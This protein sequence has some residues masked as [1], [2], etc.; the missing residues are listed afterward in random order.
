MK[1][2]ITVLL[3][4]AF[5]MTGC[6][7]KEDPKT[8][9]VVQAI[10]SAEV[11]TTAVNEA[12]T[13]KQLKYV[14]QKGSEYIY[15]LTSIGSDV[16]SIKADTAMENAVQSKVTYKIGITPTEFDEDGT[17]TLNVAF[18]G[19]SLEAK[20]NKEKV[21]YQSGTKLDSTQ[22]AQ[23]FQYEALVNNSYGARLKNNGEILEIFKTDKIIQKIID[24]A[25]NMPKALTPEQK[26]QVKREVVESV[27]RPSLQQ[28]F[29]KLSDA[30][31]SANSN[32]SIDQVLPVNQII[33]FGT[34]QIYSVKGYEMLN[35]AKMARIDISAQSTPEINPEAKK[36]GIEVEKSTLDGTGKL[37]FDVN[38]N[39]LAY[40]KTKLL[41][42]TRINRKSKGP[43]GEMKVS[44][45]NISEKTNVFQLIEVRSH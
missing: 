35:D 15:V 36:N 3:I 25:P 22:K 11:K 28:I 38:K 42:D 19:I 32:W 33:Q 40:G 27:L 14:P 43:K 18:L 13:D 16:A 6:R 39:M 10:D 30:K 31:V 26:E 23:F 8:A 44:S 5:V 20:S 9:Q 17:L 29:R 1:Y 45:S 24:L 12:L 7:K 37:F 4:F 41:I 34:K 2:F 21:S